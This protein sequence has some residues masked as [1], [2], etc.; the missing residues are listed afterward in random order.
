MGDLVA[1]LVPRDCASEV[2][3]GFQNTPWEAGSLRLEAGKLLSLEAGKGLWLVRL[4][5]LKGRQSL[6]A[7][8]LDGRDFGCQ[9]PAWGHSVHLADHC[10]PLVVPYEKAASPTSQGPNRGTC[11]PFLLSLLPCCLPHLFFPPSPLFLFHSTPLFACPSAL[12]PDSF[13]LGV[14]PLAV[15]PRAND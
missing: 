9:G 3:W 13:G 5:F 12:L 6:A 8:G 14:R 4:P 2:S 10:H 15:R 1:S 7:S 11:L